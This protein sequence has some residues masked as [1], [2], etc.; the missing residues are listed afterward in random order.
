MSGDS[1]EGNDYPVFLPGE[2]HGQRSLVGCSPWD[3]K[4]S[5]MTK[6]L[7]HTHMSEEAEERLGRLV[8]LYRILWINICSSLSYRK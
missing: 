6:R 5:D 7:T 2:L 3:L 8:G 4:E 1:E